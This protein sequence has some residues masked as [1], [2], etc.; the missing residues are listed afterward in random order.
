MFAD[1]KKSSI[2][3]K[4]KRKKKYFVKSKTSKKYLSESRIGLLQNTGTQKEKN[5]LP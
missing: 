2:T 4:K 3:K 5:H 1:D